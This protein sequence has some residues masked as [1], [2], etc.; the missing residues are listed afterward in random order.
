MTHL[1][2]KE[3]RLSAE[4]FFFSV[5]TCW[6]LL[7]LVSLLGGAQGFRP[8]VPTTS[9][10]LRR[11][12]LQ[13]ASVQRA[14]TKLNDIAPNNANTTSS[15]PSSSS[16]SGGSNK[17]KEIGVPVL[18]AAA[19]LLAVGSQAGSLQT[20]LTTLVDSSVSKIAGMGNWG[21]LYFAAVS[22]KSRSL[23]C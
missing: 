12:S 23:S 11:L 15:A 20:S 5:M 14:A 16:G 9:L 2:A 8:W 3:S 1:K 6:L 18:L 13:P 22:R 17:L 21:Y 7:L 10:S 4:L 19:V